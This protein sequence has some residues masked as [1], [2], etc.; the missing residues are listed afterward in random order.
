MDRK[1][2]TRIIIVSSIVL[3]A[4]LWRFVNTIPNVTP[5]A[6]IAL[7][8]GAYMGRKWLALLIPMAIMFISDVF[9][10]FHSTMIAV[11]LSFALSVWLGYSLNRKPSVLSV[12]ASSL[13]SSILFF[14]IT[15]FGAWL[16]NMGG[17]PMT[18]VGLTECYI[19]GIPFFR[20]EI[21]STL[22]FSTVL[23]GSFEL[24]KKRVPA[25]V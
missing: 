23:F 25:F 4:V 2:I 8:S 21:L 18:L 11:Y 14:I 3:L 12:F 19:A 13:G 10:G 7:F 5:I 16:S 24:L 1:T 17:Y 15:N 9:I 22:A 6:A 20:W